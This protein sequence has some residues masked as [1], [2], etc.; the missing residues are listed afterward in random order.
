MLARRVVSPEGGLNGGV[1][2][3]ALIGRRAV[4]ALVADLAAVLLF[5]VIGRRSH[6]EDGAFLGLLRTLWP[7]ATGLLA[8][9]VATARLRRPTAPW[10]TGVVLVVATVAIG[11]LLRVAS[12][13]GVALSFVVVATIALTVLLVG[14]RAVLS[15][16]ER[17]RG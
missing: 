11:M 5:V 4:L 16:V 12:R 17:R 15:A 13:Q 6:D 8:G 2:S 10:P 9:W 14:W 7:F 3:T 1:T